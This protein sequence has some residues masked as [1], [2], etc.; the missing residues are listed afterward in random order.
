MLAVSSAPALLQPEQASPERAACTGKLAYSNVLRGNGSNA[1]KTA[2]SVYDSC[3]MPESA[4]LAPPDKATEHVRPAELAVRRRYLALGLV[5]ALSFTHFIASAFYSLIH[6]S[7]AKAAPYQLQFGVLIAIL[8]ELCSLLLLWFILSGQNRSWRDIGW[9]PTWS[10]IPYAFALILVTR[11]CQMVINLWFQVFYRTISGHPLE[12]TTT[13]GLLEA[14]ISVL[15]IALVVINPVFEELIVR[16]YAMSEMIALGRGPIL[17]VLVSVVVQMSY[18]VYQGTLRG[19]A[20]A[21]SFTLS[22]IF[23]LKTK[24]IVPVVLAHLWVDVYALIRFNT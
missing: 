4:I 2:D 10:D 21:V 1:C 18:H 13:R 11:I 23:F 14:G 6:P 16:A 8:W 12:P 5:L 17:A 20:L 3:A 19:I 24:R 7:T 15:T 9:N 22:S